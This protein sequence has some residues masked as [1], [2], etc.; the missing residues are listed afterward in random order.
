[1]TSPKIQKDIVSACAQE[2]VKA[3]I[4]D[5]DGDYF[6]ILADES[7]DI[8]HHEQMALAL[9]Y[10][11][12]KGQVNEP[13][14]SL[15]RVSD[16]SAKSLKEAVLSL[17]MKHSLSPSKIRGQGYDGATVAKKHKEVE[18][19][20]AIVTNVLN[21][22]G[23]SFKR[24]DQLRDHQAEL[25][26]QLLESGEVQSGKGLN[27]EQG[28]QRP[29][30]TR[31]G[32]HCK[33]LDN[34]VILVSSIV[35]VLG[36]IE[37]EGDVNDRLQAEVFSSKIKEFEFVFLLHLMLKVLIMSNELSKALQTKDQDIVNAM[38]FLDITKERLQGMRDKGWEPLMDE[39]YLFCAKHDILVPKM[40]E[41]YI[42]GKSKHRP[43]SVTYS[44]HLRVELFYAVIDLQLLEL[45]SRFDVVSSNLLLGMASLNPAN[46]F[47]NFDKERIMTL[48]KHY[49]D[50][51]GE[52]KLRDLS[53]QLDTFIWHMQHGDPRFSDLKGIGDLA[54]A[55]VETNLVETYSLIY[56]FVKL[57][58][59]LPV[60]TAT[61]ERAFSSM[62]YIKDELRSSIGD[63]F[64]NESL[65]CY[66]EKEVFVNISNDAIIDR[67]Q[68]MK[69][70]R[71]QL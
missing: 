1:M 47:A 39:V 21:I 13:F 65:V 24:R 67:F 60:A 51:F 29:G 5:L 71:V 37:C 68:N 53:R 26:E 33:I 64:L 18:T 6:G 27:Q 32:S 14:I 16:T 41:F 23:V 3:I 17:L 44:H 69:T 12:K 49:P 52:L 57:T 19:F 45:N 25:L 66:F 48:A 31:W 30:D 9:R 36:V 56:L 20:F 28:L 63:A 11:D 40:E 62:K 34:F 7:K 15:V 4:D 38:V 58:L 35:H 10:V 55:L 46:S 42:P 54:K 43:S 2:T 22:I 50:E 70:R 59:I 8:S 61:V